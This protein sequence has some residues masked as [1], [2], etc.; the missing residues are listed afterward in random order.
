MTVL[1]N[2]MDIPKCCNSCHFNIGPFCNAAVTNHY[3]LITEK[4]KVRPTWCPLTDIRVQPKTD[5]KLL[6]DSG[7]EL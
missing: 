5:N 2:D 3:T 4:D 6:E 7:F 1:I